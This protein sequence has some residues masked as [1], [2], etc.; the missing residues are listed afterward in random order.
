MH[1]FPRTTAH[2]Q[3][4]PT[5]VHEPEYSGLSQI[6]KGERCSICRRISTWEEKYRF[7]FLHES[8][9]FP[10]TLEQLTR[11]AG[12]C[13]FHGAQLALVPPG[14][15]LQPMCIMFSPAVSARCFPGTDRDVLPGKGPPL[16]SSPPPLALHAMSVMMPKEERCIFWPRRARRQNPTVAL[17]QSPSVSHMF[18][19]SFPGYRVTHSCALSRTAEQACLLHWICL[20]GNGRMRQRLKQIKDGPGMTQLFWHYALQPGTTRNPAFFLHY[21]SDIHYRHSETPLPPLLQICPPI[22]IVPSARRC[23]VPGPNGWP[24]SRKIFRW[25][26]RQAIFIRS[27]PHILRHSVSATDALLPHPSGMR[28]TLHATGFARG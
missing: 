10:E 23:N 20:P 21:S 26:I 16:P 7:W 3:A 1:E 9:S 12:F 6:L 18:K 28:F 2:T 15:S 5:P 8:Y 25:T 19:C 11:S 24:G 13:F 27:A 4:T 22:T 14:H 17:S